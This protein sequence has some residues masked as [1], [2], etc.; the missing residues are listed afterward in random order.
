M[1]VPKFE[2]QNH[3][4]VPQHW[5][6][7]FR[8]SGGH[9][10]CRCGDDVSIVSTRT[11]MQE[12]YL[13]TVFDQQ[14]R[15]SDALEDTFSVVEGKDALLFKRLMTPGYTLTSDD[16][17]HLCTVLAMQASRHPDILKRGNT[18]SREFGTVLASVHKYSEAE[19]V[20]TLVDYGF[21]EEES[22]NFYI[23]LSRVPA[24]QL[25]NEL[26]ELRSLS[27]QSPDLPMQEAVKAWVEI[28]K[29]ILTM[30]MS[31]IDAIS[32]LA[33]VLGDTPIPQDNLGQ[34]FTVPLSQT[35]AVRVTPSQTGCHPSITRRLATQ[36]DV[37]E[38]N[39]WQWENSAQIIVGSS[40]K[41]LKS[42]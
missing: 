24:E 18:L 15:P 9:L 22:G 41:L 26:A 7:G 36:N 25:A 16:H 39:R 20:Q 2:K 35:L 33:F 34:G 13:Y 38:I 8:S 28:R 29:V 37:D 40:V 11:T 10:F 19:F 6:R 12:D 17:E 42:F 1:T 21:P 14:W 4:Y 30:E 23:A 27:P 31:L 5:Q 3:H 32:P